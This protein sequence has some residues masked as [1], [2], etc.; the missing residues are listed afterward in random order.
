MKRKILIGIICI[1]LLI[2]F[3]HAEE[4]VLP[5]E[6]E[7]IGEALGFTQ[8]NEIFGLGVEQGR[9]YIDRVTFNFVTENA[10]LSVKGNLFKNII[11]NTKKVAYITINKSDA[12]ILEAGFTT[13][14]DYGNY[15][16][17]GK[18]YMVPNGTIIYFSNKEGIEFD[19]P[20]QTDLRDYPNLLNYFLGQKT[21]IRGKNI[22]ISEDFELISGEVSV[23]KNGYLIEYG[24]VDYKKNFIDAGYFDGSLLI[25]NLESDLSNYDGRWMRQTEKTLEFHNPD[26]R[27]IFVDFLEG[28]EILKIDEGDYFGIYLSDSSSAKFENRDLEELIPKLITQGTVN[29]YDDSMTFKAVGENI[30]MS[31]EMSEPT[32]TPLEL[33]ML[34]ND[35]FPIIGE[36]GAG[37]GKNYYDIADMGGHKIVIDNFKRYTVIPEGETEG[38]SISDWA[39]KNKFSSKLKYNYPSLEDFEILFDGSDKTISFHNLPK[40]NQDALLGRLRD[41]YSLLPEKMKNSL[42]DIEFAADKDFEEIFR[43]NGG[44]IDA[45]RVGAFATQNG[46]V[47]FRDV[48]Q[49]DLEIFRHETAHQLHFLIKGIRTLNKNPSKNTFLD[50]VGQTLNYLKKNEFEKKWR[51][52]LPRKYK[53]I[54]DEY[55]RHIYLEESKK[56]DAYKNNERTW[57]AGYG[58]MR[59]YGSTNIY[60]DVATFQEDAHFPGRYGRVLSAQH[61]YREVYKGKLDLLYEYG[62]ISGE[63]YNA[64]LEEA[65]KY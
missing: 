25:A 56:S 23:N 36:L 62:F 34:N 55:G 22:Q 5:S 2:S 24:E 26:G 27:E 53:S 17:G 49:F 38:T 6:L 19:F 29:V 54:I 28:H 21:K 48:N 40:G 44:Q 37:E 18:T 60:E 11:P 15:T 45:D 47:V 4:G 7:N 1:F 31:F 9:E 12:I 41:Y 64:I 52:I 8:G 63:E 32:T 65:E 30:L 59:A 35:G 13:N 39:P 61:P 10:Q 58:F 46:K 3:I 14:G 51:E 50:K 43:S 16:F 42:I 57:G 20:D 33:E